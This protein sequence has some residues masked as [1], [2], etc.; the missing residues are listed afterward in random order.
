MKTLLLAALILLPFSNAARADESFTFDCEVR[1]IGKKGQVSKISFNQEAAVLDGLYHEAGDVGAHAHQ[2]I[3]ASTNTYHFTKEARKLVLVV[4]KS[5]SVSQYDG[6]PHGDPTNIVSG[7][8][9]VTVD[10]NA[11]GV[12]RKYHGVCSQTYKGD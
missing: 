2:N 6:Y 9:H 10:A 11:N 3:V 12:A 5:K 1:S 8:F 7:I 4:S